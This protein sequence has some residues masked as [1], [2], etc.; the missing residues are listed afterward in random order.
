MALGQTI[1]VK[2]SEYI[3]QCDVV[4]HVVG[5]RS[6]NEATGGVAKPATVQHLLQIHPDLPQKLGLDEATLNALTYTQWEAWLAVYHR[7]EHKSL[8]LYI[9]VP[10]ADAPRDS[11][12][13]DS[14][15]AASQR[16]SQQA[17]LR[18]LAAHGRYPEIS[19]ANSDQLCLGLVGLRDLLATGVRSELAI[20]NILS[21]S[22]YRDSLAGFR[23][24][25]T[26]AGLPFQEPIP[27]HPTHPEELLKR[28]ETSSDARGVLLAGAG[29]VGKTRTTFE[30][31]QLGESRGW[32]VIYV[33]PGQPVVT[34]DKVIEAALAHGPGKTMVVIE[35]FDQMQE[36]DLGVL[37]RH[38]IQAS[39]Q[40]G[41]EFGI[42]ANCRPG[43]LLKHHPEREACF[44]TVRLDPTIEEAHRLSVYVATCTAP[45]ARGALGDAEL[46]RLCGHRPIIALLVA[47]QLEQ[48][49]ATSRIVPENLSA[50]RTGD[51]GHWLRRRL[52]EDKLITPE[53]ES[54]YE[55]ASPPPHLMAAAA[56]LACAPDEE[57]ALIVAAEQALIEIG[58]PASTAGRIIGVLR[59]VGWLEH[60]GP[61]LHVVHDVVADELMEQS[62]FE[63][64][65]VRRSDL[66]AILV[67]GIMRAR[68]LGRISKT[69]TRVAGAL[70]PARAAG[71]HASLSA[72]LST[73]ASALGELLAAAEPDSGAY[74]LG[75]VLGGSS[76]E[77]G[78]VEHWSALVAPWL[79]CYG[80]RY[81][82]R[83]L[84][85]R[86]LRTGRESVWNALLG[87]CRI[88]LEKWRT[89]R[90][91]SFV[92]GPLLHGDGK[93]PPPEFPIIQWSLQWL[94]A[95]A[96]KSEAQFVFYSLLGREDVEGAQAGQAVKL[97]LQWLEAFADD[98][99]ASFVL[100][101][102]LRFASPACGATP[103][104]IQT[105]GHTLTWLTRWGDTVQAGY[106]LLAWHVAGW[107]QSVSN[108]EITKV[109][110]AW[111]KANR[112]VGSGGP[113]TAITLAICAFDS[114]AAVRLIANAQSWVFNHKLHQSVGDVLSTLLAHCRCANPLAGFIA[115]MA[116]HYAWH[117]RKSP[118]RK[119]LA[120]VLTILTAD[121]PRKE[122]IEVI[123]EES[124]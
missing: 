18:R 76:L 70:S 21:L 59:E 36:L 14:I 108:V 110:E 124:T 25:L 113:A 78:A 118:V 28:L 22:D 43:L 29:G 73:H 114:P 103:E 34:A 77:D 13:T 47:Q 8:L 5:D 49:A 6:G 75:A 90:V 46:M 79:E 65:T 56:A 94:E 121:D 52:A 55:S 119:V 15:K 30:T 61:W 91:A 99:A 104:D 16:E 88:W 11:L 53:A 31:A 98:K 20:T 24:F 120:R 69:A 45:K 48:L 74:A 82:A 4:V 92:L 42:I 111:I 96:D 9:A 1:L 62:V 50:V 115:D 116:I 40:R 86:G 58:K 10:S 63:L 60:E 100:G 95:F 80:A 83:H 101:P 107:T 7:F 54:I 17:H 27:G 19:F 32:R 23:R 67:P 109:A 89:D 2:L 37:R 38:L 123:L 87:A 97:A 112:G 72:W 84:L 39:H 81:E 117:R 12:L 71:F 106:V 102:L 93:R 51:L 41:I 33:L 64:N 44:D 122:E 3:R 85:F 35:Y 26:Q 68:S 57:A 105:V 66:S